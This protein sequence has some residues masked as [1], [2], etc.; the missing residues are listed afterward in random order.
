VMSWSL[1]LHRNV[2]AAGSSETLVPVYET[3]GKIPRAAI[4]IFIFLF[5][6]RIIYFLL[7]AFLFLCI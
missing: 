6:C 4:S 1:I 2:E 7:H 5:Y 3:T